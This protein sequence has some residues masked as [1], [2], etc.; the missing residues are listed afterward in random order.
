MV[1]AEEETLGETRS[2]ERAEEWFLV[3][4]SQGF[5]PMQ[6]NLRIVRHT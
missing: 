2:R 4:E 3:L 5:S 6:G 1:A